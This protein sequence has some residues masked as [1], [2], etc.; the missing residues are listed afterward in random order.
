MATVKCTITFEGLSGSVPAVDVVLIAKDE[1]WIRSK[2]VQDEFS[3]VNV[4]DSS[5]CVVI[6]QSL[7]KRRGNE[8]ELTA[9][10]RILKTGRNNPVVEVKGEYLVRDKV[11]TELREKLTEL[12][13]TAS[14]QAGDIGTLKGEIKAINHPTSGI[15]T[16]ATAAL[17][18]AKLQL[19]TDIGTVKSTADTATTELSDLTGRVSSLDTQLTGELAVTKEALSTLKTGI[20]GEISTLKKNTNRNPQGELG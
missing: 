1:D 6:F 18:A 15:L 19:E 7:A 5:T 4:P 10:V 14:T 12:E 13:T 16:T 2:S 3:F 9:P 20:E 11:L 8:Y 17:S